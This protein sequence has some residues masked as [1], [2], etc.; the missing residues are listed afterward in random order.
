MVQLTRVPARMKV[1]TCVWAVDGWA[2]AFS[3]CFF[4]CSVRHVISR[5]SSGRLALRALE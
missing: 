2:I 5:I 1:S 4:F 3:F